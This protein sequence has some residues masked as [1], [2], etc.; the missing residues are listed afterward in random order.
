MAACR[1][2]PA[3]LES[4]TTSS[5]SPLLAMVWSSLPLVQQYILAQRT[6]LK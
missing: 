1:A 2:V 6:L 4:F 5:S 3:V